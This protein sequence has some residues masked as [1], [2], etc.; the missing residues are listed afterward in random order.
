MAE[1]LTKFGLAQCSELLGFAPKPWIEVLERADMLL[2]LFQPRGEDTQGPHDRDEIYIVASGSGVFR[3]G[4]APVAFSAG[5]VLFVPAFVPHR[6][7]SFSADFRTWVVFFG[8]K[9]GSAAQAAA[10]E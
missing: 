8:P 2:E 1:P 9:G 10:T 5:D 4:E 7:E 3:Y 6:F